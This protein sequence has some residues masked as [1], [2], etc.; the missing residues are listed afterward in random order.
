VLTGGGAPVAIELPVA[1][2]QRLTIHVDPTG[3]GQRSDHVSLA[4]AR[5][6]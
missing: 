4:L 2:A 3:D 1:G 6:Q 5:F